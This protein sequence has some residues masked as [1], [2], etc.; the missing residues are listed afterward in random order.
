MK[1]AS[2]LL[3]YA[4]DDR[5]G[6][7]RGLMTKGAK[8]TGKIWLRVGAGLIVLIAAA[9]VADYSFNV[10]ILRR[11]PGVR[12]VTCLRPVIVQGEAMAPAIPNKTRVTFNQ[13]LDDGQRQAIELGKVILYENLGSQRI[14]RVVARQA[15]IRGFGYTVRQD[16]RPEPSEVRFDRIIGVM[17]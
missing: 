12:S 14:V 8:M 16:N 2:L 11:L 6:C 15:D 7:E 1:T 17:K 10:P 4:F 5:L 9:L 3:K 13:C